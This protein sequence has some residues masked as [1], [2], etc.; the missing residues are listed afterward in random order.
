MHVVAIAALDQP[1]I[2]AMVKG[3]LELRLLLQMAAVAKLRLRFDQQ[4]LARLS[5][6]RRMAGDAAHVILRVLRIEGVH[7]FVAP[8]MAG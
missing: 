6:M 5:V 4:V 1:F 3:H 2:D 8:G 7:M